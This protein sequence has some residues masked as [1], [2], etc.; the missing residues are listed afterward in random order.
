MKIL[1]IEFKNINSFAGEWEIHF[2]R[3]PLSDTG[4]FAIVGPN[5]SGK[6][7]ILDA[8]TLGLYGETPR[9][10]NPE[11]KFTPWM[12]D[13]SFA[14]V[15]FSIGENQYRSEWR[16]RS[17]NGDLE[18]PEMRLIAL[19]GKET[20]LED[21]IIRVRSRIE[22]L[23]G[24]DFKRFC[25]SILLAQ[26]EFAA[27][28]TSLES[29]RAEIL[30]KIIGPE[31]KRE[32]EMS[33]RSRAA[34]ESEKLHQLKEVAAGF[35]KAD[36]GRLNQALQEQEQIQD[37]LMEA[38]R[39]LIELQETGAWLE[40]L[41]QLEAE[42][43]STT[44]LAG[45]AAARV[46]RLQEQLLAIKDAEPA[47]LLEEDLE[48]L[49]RYE[50]EKAAIKDQLARLEQDIP[51]REKDLGE[52]EEKLHRNLTEL[53]NARKQLAEQGD[54]W[55]G[56][57]LSDREI[58]IESQ[59]LADAVQRFES[60]ESAR[61]S[62]NQ[63]QSEL[64]RQIGT[65]VKEQRDLQ[66]R[67][68]S[69]AVDENLEVDIALFET[70]L[71]RLGD[72]QQQL[73]LRQGPKANLLKVER[74]SAK[75]LERHERAVQ[76]LREQV[77]RLVKRRDESVQRVSDLL[78]NSSPDFWK[79]QIQ[80]SR[81]KLS[82]CRAL[83]GIGRKYQE[84]QKN[85][86]IDE[87][88]RRIDSEIQ[89]VSLTLEQESMH[90]TELEEEINWR[91]KVRQLA[92]ERSALQKG[93]A[94]PLCGSPD[95]PFVEQG[96]PD[97]SEFDRTVQAQEKKIAALQDRL[98]SL[99]ATAAGLQ[100]RTDEMEKLQQLWTRTCYKAELDWAVPDA[101]LALA[102]SHIQRISIKDSKSRIRSARWQRW[103]NAWLQRALFRKEAKLARREQETDNVRARHNLDKKELTRVESELEK[104][105]H[106]DRTV[107]SKLDIRLRDYNERAPGPGAETTLLQRL[108]KRLQSYRRLQEEWTA[109]ASRLQS[110]EDEKEALSDEREQL[111]ADAAVQQ[112]EIE[113]LQ[114][115]LNELKNNRTAL[116]GS[117]DPSKER[118]TLESEITAY[119]AEQSA[120]QQ[121]IRSSRHLLAEDQAKF[122]RLSEQGEQIRR[123]LHELQ[124]RSLE[125][126]EAAGFVSIEQ[127]RDR[128][129]MLRSEQGVK[130]QQLAAERT[131]ADANSRAASL[132]REL[133]ALRSE[134]ETTD[135]ME[136]IRGRI[137][138]QK[139]QCDML[140]ES[141][142]SID[143]LVLD[144]RSAEREYRDIQ[145]A[146][147]E[148][149]T[150][151]AD[152][153][154]EERSLQFPD[155]AEINARLQ[156]LMLDRLIEYS[157]GYLATLS[158]RY[159]LRSEDEEGL[160]F[161]VRD[162]LQG[163]TSRSSQTLSG[164]ETFV[165]SLCL[166]LGLS[167]MACKHRKIETLFIDEG[168]GSLDDENLYRVMTTLKGLRDNGKMVGI[169]SH[170]KRLAEEIP[171][172]IKVE[173]QVSGMSRMT[174]VA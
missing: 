56:A 91:G 17:R 133:D 30:D 19:N 70:E 123:D 120:L 173:K 76:T 88:L 121:E 80:E 139:K 143:R 81:R 171:T 152:A 9:I 60:A 128:I 6:S 36:K 102:E 29:E 47:R 48:S 142:E 122:T 77:N 84:Q 3:P 157:N 136:G 44:E 126:A 83:I 107:R 40:K 95:H 114:R 151:W 150:V 89:E 108:S 5:G 68:A 101:D 61:K 13:G 147:A 117:I 73:K 57:L 131:L 167:E 52:L 119:S 71:K 111:Q 82:V 154:A 165:L 2:H 164:G 137:E 4:L 162:S 124:R 141:K 135:S 116:Y 62:K 86:E 32:L 75:E 174:I 99:Q 130:E 55:S 109:M 37:E 64:E 28:L 22:E 39:I 170:V 33:I 100:V 93:R 63:R 149:E 24:L 23:T 1:G 97:F 26:G 103:K 14:A 92:A 134:R 11:A 46:A 166:A 38:E 132:R 72:I 155:N 20:L 34:V 74:A 69:H 78:Q 42:D 153:V 98:A 8:I 161:L 168:F 65:S 158:G 12:A 169:I 66:R 172:Q 67:L 53:E 50:S 163:K 156:R 94:C 49:D 148:Q 90:L 113:N 118:E 7:S 115:S 54:T 110:I 140:R 125:Q 43:R 104:L 35:A 96:A 129:E 85:G 160:G 21:R 10:K 16:V 87:K 59:R 15:T 51:A 58:E 41:T 106:E 127:V 31:M 25:R 45:E 18:A 146:V 79:K 112:K 159:Q 27:F 145:E 138:E 144:Q 105:Q